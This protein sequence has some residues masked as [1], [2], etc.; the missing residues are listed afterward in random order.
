MN[1]FDCH[2][3]T[4]TEIPPSENLMHNT[5]CLDLARA[6][7]FTDH[8]TQIFAVWIDQEKIL[9]SGASTEDAFQEAYQRSMRLMLEQSAYLKWCQNAADMQEAHEQGKAAVFLAVEDVSVMGRLVEQIRGLGFRF[10]MLTWN[11]E[12]AYGCGAVTDQSKGLTK[13]GREL[14]GQLLDQQIILDIS[15]LS[16]QGVED[17]FQLTDCPVIASHSNVREVCNHPRNLKKEHIR[18]LIRRN[19]LC[20][21]NFYQEFVARR[22]KLT[23]LLRHMDTVLKMGG[24]DILALGGDLDGCK[25][26]LVPGI[27]GVQ[28][29]PDLKALMEREGFGRSVIEKIFWKNAERFLMLNA[30][31]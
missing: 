30:G 4:L 29:I 8:Y 23:D 5:C 22:P 27:A 19:G 31:E 25:N 13:E 7:N 21:I 28:S 12:N 14:A 6:R 2:A 9:S 1:Y 18:E 10:A 11:Y 20:G 15:H 17:I 26:Q 16:D 24:E 3:D